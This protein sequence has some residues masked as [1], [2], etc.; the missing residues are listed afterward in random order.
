MTKHIQIY[1]F[2]FGCQAHKILKEKNITTLNQ[3]EMFTAEELLTFRGLGNKS[4]KII[5]KHMFLNGFS[6]KGEILS[7]NSE[8]K[9][10]EKLLKISKDMHGCLKTLLL[11]EKRVDEKIEKLDKMMKILDLSI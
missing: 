5:R 9:N 11:L 2:P 3:L 6:L 7:T 8:E 4:L 1:G 10:Y